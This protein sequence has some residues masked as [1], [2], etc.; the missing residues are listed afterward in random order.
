MEQEIDSYL[1]D[2]VNSEVD[3]IEK[4]SAQREQDLIKDKLEMA[5]LLAVKDA[6]VSEN[7]KKQ[8]KFEDPSVLE[9]EKQLG[10]L[11]YPETVVEVDQSLLETVECMQHK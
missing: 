11:I 1:E 4:F 9:Y 6:P 8:K 2:K 5:V 7:R 10:P 3:A